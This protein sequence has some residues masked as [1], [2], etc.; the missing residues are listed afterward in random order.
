LG[1]NVVLAVMLGEY[2]VNYVHP[3]LSE[4]NMSIN[5]ASKLSSIII[6]IIFILP[7]A[8]FNRL[9]EIKFIYYFNTFSFLLMTILVVIYAFILDPNTI[10]DRLYKIPLYPHSNSY[11]SQMDYFMIG[12]PT[13]LYC[14]SNQAAI[15]PIYTDLHNPTKLR[16]SKIIYRGYTIIATSVLLVGIFGIWTFSD[17]GFIQDDNIGDYTDVIINMKQFDNQIPMQIG[18]AFYLVQLIFSG[19]LNLVPLRDTI[20]YLYDSNIVLQ[21]VS[22]FKLLLFSIM[23]LSIQWG[24]ACITNKVTMVTGFIGNVLAPIQIFIL[25][26]ML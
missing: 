3:L 11:L 24:I 20:L 4:L 8:L 17:I 22:K 13:V 2:A 18:K 26:T 12:F 16:M 25:P 10:I 14:L 19:I 23:L 15:I 5:M 1:Y 6:C 7:L 9:S 21:K